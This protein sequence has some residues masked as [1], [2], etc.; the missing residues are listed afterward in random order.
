M[1]SINN[2]WE[3]KGWLLEVRGSLIY[4]S[5]WQSLEFFSEEIDQTE[6]LSKNTFRKPARE[7]LNEL[8]C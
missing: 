2:K 1:M 8:M 7:V 5:K 4:S 3:E 6:I